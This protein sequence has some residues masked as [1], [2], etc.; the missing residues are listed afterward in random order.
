MLQ[1]C[2]TLYNTSQFQIWM[3][4]LAMFEFWVWY[5]RDFEPPETRKK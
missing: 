4:A 1:I 5:A 3:L 2:F